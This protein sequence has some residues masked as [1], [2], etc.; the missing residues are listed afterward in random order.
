[1]NCST[2]DIEI[3]HRVMMHR[4]RCH[5]RMKPNDYIYAGHSQRT[6][7]W[8]DSYYLLS[9]LHSGTVNIYTHLIGICFAIDLVWDCVDGIA[10]IACVLGCGAFVNFYL[11]KCDIYWIEM[12]S[13]G[14]LGFSILFFNKSRSSPG[15]HFK[16][17]FYSA[18]DLVDSSCRTGS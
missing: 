1:M 14:V 15:T 8:H 13:F 18:L 4:D 11:L 6:Y 17:H 7:Y 5:E 16:A 2:N 3:G 10:Y 9:N 12:L